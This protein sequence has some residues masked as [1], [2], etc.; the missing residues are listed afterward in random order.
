MVR[1][2]EYDPMPGRAVD[3]DRPDYWDDV[4]W[5][6]WYREHNP[7]GEVGCLF[8]GKC[9]MPGSHYVS[10]CHTPDMLEPNAKLSGPNGPQEKQ[11]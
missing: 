1:C 6:A 7:R 8:P 9:C 2:E 10:E 3:D 4:D 5:E 11:Q